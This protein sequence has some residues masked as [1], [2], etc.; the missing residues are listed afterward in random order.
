LQPDRP[1]PGYDASSAGGTVLGLDNVPLELPIAGIGSR[2]LAA[3]IDHLL[4][5]F[6]EIIWIFGGIAAV[7][8]A[9]LGG[10]GI[11]LLVVGFF[12]LQWGYF[13]LFEI[14][15]DGQTPGKLAVG[16]RVV[17]AHGGRATAAAFLVRNVLRTFDLFVGLPIMAVDR[18][19]RRLGDAVAGTLV[20][21]DREGRA[22]VELGRQPS[23]WGP[24]EVAVVE[25]FLRRAPWMEPRRA[26][27][28]GAQ[29][30]RWIRRR[31]PE[32]WREVFGDGEPDGDPVA[33]VRQALRVG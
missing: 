32:L 8:L 26:Q 5:F 15:L 25:S 4:L 14:F 22:E 21:H 1:L 27:Q 33:R 2:T 9:Q 30:L 20:V 17:A 29:L 19:C 16:L 11:G 12:V 31:E 28:L 7:G 13:A 3:S 10:W 24:R 23:S 6:L 18:R